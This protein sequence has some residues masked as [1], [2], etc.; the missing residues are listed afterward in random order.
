[1][2]IYDPPNQAPPGTE[3]PIGP[4]INSPPPSYAEHAS[5]PTPN[6]RRSPT[7]PSAPPADVLAIKAGD[8][9]PYTAIAASPPTVVTSSVNTK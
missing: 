2:G 7:Y 8:P 4:N 5:Y 1:M 3:Y 6:D 9:P